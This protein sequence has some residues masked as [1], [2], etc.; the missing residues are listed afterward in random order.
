[1]MKKSYYNLAWTSTLKGQNESIWGLVSVHR[2]P[3]SPL[4]LVLHIKAVSMG[5]VS[6]V[7]L[8]DPVSKMLEEVQTL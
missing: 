8:Q 1:M 7:Q 3:C 2:R 6:P 4:L 5:D